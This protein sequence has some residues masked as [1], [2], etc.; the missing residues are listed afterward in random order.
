MIIA[1]DYGESKCGYAFGEKFIRKSGT[2]K[3]SELNNILKNFK[4]VV[5]GFPLSM[6]GNYS[7]QS[8][9]VLKYAEKLLRK[10]FK[11]FL[12][13]ERLTTSMAASFGIK[14]DDTFSARQI[15]L[16][17]ISNPKVAQEFRLLKEL[18]ER[19]IEVPGKVLYY[20]SLPI[21]NLKGDVCTKNYSLAYLHMKKGN[22]V[23]GN[24]DTIVEKYDLIITQ[25]EDKDK[26]GKYLKSDGQLLVI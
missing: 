20:E 16:D 23:F 13:D 1:I 12:Y 3:R 14:E 2:V 6:S 19:K 5:L 25:R 15:F 26:V 4:E 22:F 17:Y 9:K 24:P 8:Y 21:K 18:E 7:T 11:V 10:G